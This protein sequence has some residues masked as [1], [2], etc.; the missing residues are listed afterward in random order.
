MNMM[1]MGKM[2]SREGRYSSRMAAILKSEAV[3]GNSHFGNQ[4]K[5]DC[6]QSAVIDVNSY[7][8]SG[9]IEKAAKL[10]SLLLDSMLKLSNHEG[11]EENKSFRAGD[12]AEGLIR[13]DVGF[14]REMSERHPE[15]KKTAQDVQ[16][17]ET[18]TRFLA[19]H[20]TSATIILKFSAGAAGDHEP[21]TERKT[22][23]ARVTHRRTACSRPCR[24][25]RVKSPICR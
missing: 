4:R 25:G 16:L 23:D 17:D 3:E 2:S 13:D 9:N 19:R 1:Y 8:A 5:C 12:K 22:L 18:N 24:N 21:Y 7:S 6:E 15:Q 20:G 11:G 14:G 10:A